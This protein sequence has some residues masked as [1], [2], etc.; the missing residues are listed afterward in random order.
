MEERRAGPRRAVTVPAVEF[1]VASEELVAAAGVLRSD[2]G[3]VSGTEAQWSRA[4][5]QVPG[6]AVGRARRAAQAFCDT[7]GAAAR[8]AGIGLH[9]LG[10]RVAAAAGEYD[11]V[12]QRLV[13]GPPRQDANRV[14]SAPPRLMP[15]GGPPTP[16]P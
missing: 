15:S 1:G 9:R 14:D 6:W 12:E 8:D 10:D 11:S 3:R 13:P 16:S 4:A 7:L 2:A 5:E